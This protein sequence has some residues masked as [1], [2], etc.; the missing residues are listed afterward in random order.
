MS[1]RRG[2]CKESWLSIFMV[3]GLLALLV[4]GLWL[5]SVLVF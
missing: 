1:E 4:I 5:N 3:G 2:L